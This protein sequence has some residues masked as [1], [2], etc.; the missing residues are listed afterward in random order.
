[1]LLQKENIYKFEHKISNKKKKKNIKNSKKSSKK[2]S[3]KKS[4]KKKLQD[5]DY[6]PKKK[7]TE[8]FTKTNKPND[9]SQ[10]SK[11]KLKDIKIMF[12]FQKRKGGK[13]KSAKISNKIKGDKQ[14]A[15]HFNDFELNSFTYQ[16]A[17][18]YDRREYMDYYKS[19]LKTKHPIIFGF[20]PVNDY[21]T[22]IVKVCLFFLS[23]CIYYAINAVFI[24]DSTIHKIYED[25]GSYNLLYS[26]PQ[27][28]YSFVIAHIITIILKFAFLSERNIIQIKKED[29]LDSAK[30]LVD[31][32]KRTIIIKYIIFFV[33][34]IIFLIFFWYYLSS[35]GAVFQNSQVYLIKNTLMSFLIAIIYPFV[36]NLLP[37]CFR[38]PSLKNNNKECLYKTS[39]IIQII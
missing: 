28:I 20:V 27:I 38:M 12:N 29:S 3:S 7:R 19:L 10:S 9:I 18:K 1:M 32:V 4:S 15:M 36:I 37:G 35:F 30:S 25:G 33:A 24:T 2:S 13:N 31:K 5:C 11:L 34:G 14:I 21:N 8:Q 6:P 26:L 39:K 23:F 16:E 17:L 22:M